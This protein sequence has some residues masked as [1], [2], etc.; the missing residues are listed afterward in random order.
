MEQQ[1]NR[2]VVNTPN[3]RR[4][5]NVTARSG[6]IFT[7]GRANLVFNDLARKDLN[8]TIQLHEYSQVTTL[9]R[10]YADTPVLAEEDHDVVIIK[11]KACP[12]C[13]ILPPTGRG[14]TSQGPIRCQNCWD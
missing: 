9:A 1:W 6:G 11:T 7:H 13:G 8:P 12:G 3:G 5:I 14:R 4:S 2:A 10:P